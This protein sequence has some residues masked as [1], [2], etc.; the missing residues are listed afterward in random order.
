M[1]VTVGRSNRVGN[2]EVG[3]GEAT[4]LLVLYGRW[5]GAVQLTPDH[6]DTIA[7]RLRAEAAGVRRV[8]QER[9]EGQGG[10]RS[11]PEQGSC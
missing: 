10:Q 8:N 1:R 3:R 9:T 6:A 4:V 11:E 5:P 7:E 2:V